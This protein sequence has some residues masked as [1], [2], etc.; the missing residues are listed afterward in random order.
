MEPV[1]LILYNQIKKRVYAEQPK[2]SAYRSM[3]V[4]K[5]YKKRFKQKY[6]NA[7]PFKGGK[8]RGLKRWID[9]KWINVCSRPPR[10]C[11]RTMAKQDYPYC[12]PSVRVSKK[13]PTLASELSSF[14]KKRLCAL[15]KKKKSKIYAKI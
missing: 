3:R 2:H 12:R 8:E 10:P 1:D 11:G 15:K 5:E 14:E 13:T 9:E 6:G 4:V 7:V